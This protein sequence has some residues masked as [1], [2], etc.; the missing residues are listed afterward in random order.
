VIRGAASKRDNAFVNGRVW[1]GGERSVF[2]KHRTPSAPAC[3][4]PVI[5][6][7]ARLVRVV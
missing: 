1:V 5:G 6:I 4:P 7:G 2:Y 3:S